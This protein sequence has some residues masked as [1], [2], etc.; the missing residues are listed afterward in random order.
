MIDVTL[1]MLF[2]LVLITGMF[3]Y[4]VGRKRERNKFQGI[5]AGVIICLIVLGMPDFI[6]EFVSEHKEGLL[7]EYIK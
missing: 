1:H 7:T 3:V 5:G 2:V 4:L 6:Q